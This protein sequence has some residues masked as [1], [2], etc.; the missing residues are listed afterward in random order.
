MSVCFCLLLFPPL[1]FLNWPAPTLAKDTPRATATCCDAPQ[2]FSGSSLSTQ[3]GEGVIVC[4]TM[5]VF[6]GRSASL[7]LFAAAVSLPWGHP[8]WSGRPFDPRRWV[9]SGRSWAQRCRL[10]FAV[11]W[12]EGPLWRAGMWSNPSSTNPL[13]WLGRV[14][15]LVS[16]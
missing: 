13:G 16:H 3:N 12:S 6:L 10:G 1:P 8:V 14:G 15:T 9:N 5:L 7:S 11:S 2:M 4:L